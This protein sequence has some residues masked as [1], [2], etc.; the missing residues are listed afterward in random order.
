MKIKMLKQMSGS[1]MYEQGKV[2]EVSEAKG[3]RLISF[4]YAEEVIEPKKQVRKC[5]NK[6]NIK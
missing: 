4:K 6:K 2:Y 5:N 3:E 1:K